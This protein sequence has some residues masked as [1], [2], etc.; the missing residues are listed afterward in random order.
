[1]ARVRKNPVE[2]QQE[3]MDIALELFCSKGY[4]QTMVQ[5]ICQQA[6][7]AKGT[8]F[9]YFPTKEDVLKAIFD[10]W[11]NR[12]VEYYT[13]QSQSMDSVEKLQMLLDFFRADNPMDDMIDRL[14]DDRRGD[15]IDLLWKRCLTRGFRP[16]LKGI[17]LQGIDEGAMMMDDLDTR[18][19]FFWAILDAA[20]PE[21]R[22]EELGEVELAHRQKVAGQLI[23]QLFSMKAGCLAPFYEAI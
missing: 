19:D 18:M 8:F 6:G 5:D 13:R 21:D 10:R 9:Y 15:L 20:W 14:W 23:E 11:T 4:E 22:Q 2:R 3:L 12:F 1:M 17:L 16:L 7:V